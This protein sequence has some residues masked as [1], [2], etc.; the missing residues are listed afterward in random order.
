MGSP[1]LPG[2]CPW[3]AGLSNVRGVKPS[4]AADVRFD[5]SQAV[6]WDVLIGGG[7][8]RVLARI[9]GGMVV[10]RR[11]AGFTRLDG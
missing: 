5:C 6:E 11:H 10:D 1:P 3:H 2:M 7:S 8:E 4:A 9:A